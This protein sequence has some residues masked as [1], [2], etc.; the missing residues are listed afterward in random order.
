MRKDFSWQLIHDDVSS[1]SCGLLLSTA[2]RAFVIKNL[3]NNTI[4][5]ILPTDDFISEYCKYPNE[6][7]A[8]I[9]SKL[10]Y[11]FEYKTVFYDSLA[12]EMISQLCESN[13]LLF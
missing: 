3:Q 6:I 9:K 13:C 4:L 12:A 2:N 8:A 1:I 5:Q 11:S 10:S 7:L